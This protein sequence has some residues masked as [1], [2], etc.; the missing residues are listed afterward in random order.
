MCFQRLANKGHDLF[1][2]LGPKAARFVSTACRKRATICFLPLAKK[3]HVLF[4][5]L[6]Q[7]S[8]DLFP[9]HVFFKRIFLGVVAAE[10]TATQNMLFQARLFWTGGYTNAFLGLVAAEVTPTRI[11]C[12]KRVFFYTGGCTH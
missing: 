4:P 11:C 12:S 9:A 8:H 3:S 6:G 7:K 2:C 1:F 10:V 5:A